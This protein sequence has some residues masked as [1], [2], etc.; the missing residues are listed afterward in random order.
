MGKTLVTSEPATSQELIFTLASA[1]RRAWLDG[2]SVVGTEYLLVE[3]A[4]RLSSLGSALSPVRSQIR[5]MVSSI[6]DEAPGGSVV[7]DNL[8]PV[9]SVA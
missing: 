9:T 8:P 3:L 5:R 6:G 1:Y 7:Q 2:R 4:S